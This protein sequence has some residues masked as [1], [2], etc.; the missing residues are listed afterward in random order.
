MS[1]GKMMLY[2]DCS[3]EICSEI[4]LRK[5]VD[6]MG[7]EARIPLSHQPM[8]PVRKERRGLLLGP[9]IHRGLDVLVRPKC[10]AL[11]SFVRGYLRLSSSD[12]FLTRISCFHHACCISSP[13]DHLN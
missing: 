6:A 9:L 3:S 11:C 13:P 2:L 5:G 12:S 4:S 10:T 7:P 8:D 1:T